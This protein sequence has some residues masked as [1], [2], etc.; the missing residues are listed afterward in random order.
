MNREER[1]AAEPQPFFDRMKT[2]KKQGTSM[3]KLVISFFLLTL[4]VSAAPDQASGSIRL[5]G[6]SGFGVNQASGSNQAS[7]GFGVRH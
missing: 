2:Q 3:K 1:S 6:Q 5:R 4:C 7:S